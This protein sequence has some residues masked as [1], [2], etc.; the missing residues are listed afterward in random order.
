V[1]DWV[2][3]DLGYIKN[4]NLYGLRGYG[5]VWGQNVIFMTAGY[6]T[7]TEFWYD[8]KFWG[9]GSNRGRSLGEWRGIVN[10]WNRDKSG[11][12]I[13]GDDPPQILPARLAPN[14]E[15]VGK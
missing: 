3:G 13:N 5:L 11:K 12:L 8:S 9:V 4:P 10:G 6:S 7:G 14:P 2:P 1:T 15:R